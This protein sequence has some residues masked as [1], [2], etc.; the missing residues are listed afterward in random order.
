M[1]IRDLRTTSIT[2]FAI[3][4]LDFRSLNLER[5]LV[6]IK[7]QFNFS[8][9]NRNNGVL[10]FNNGFIQY[11]DIQVVIDVFRIEQRKIVLTTGSNSDTNN[12]IFNLILKFLNTFETRVKHQWQYIHMFFESICVVKLNKPLSAFISK[13]DNSNEKLQAIIKNHSAEEFSI[14]VNP[15][16]IK[17][18]ISYLGTV[19][20]FNLNRIQITEKQVVIEVR[21]QTDYLQNIY[22]ISAPL[23]TTG[24]LALITE[25]EKN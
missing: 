5:T 18:Q 14:I 23:N 7:N 13:T 16:S 6:A 21:S 20:K 19:E 10:N 11:K 24:I 25:I 15:I 4:E 3:D 17:Y 12:D 22:F 2:L 8:T 1:E 9:I